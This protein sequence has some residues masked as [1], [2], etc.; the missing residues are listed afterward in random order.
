MST[1]RAFTPRFQPRETL[2]CLHCSGSSGRQWTPMIAALS[3]RFDVKAPDLL[4]YAGQ[5]CW[6]V[7]APASLDDE[8]VALEPLLEGGV[9]LF[10]HSYGGAVALQMALRWPERVKSLTLYEPVRFALLFGNPETASAGQSIVDVGRRI[11]LEVVSRLMP[12]AAAR[13]VDYWSGEG[14]W[15]QLPPQRQQIVI[16]RMP[17]V[18][19]EFEAL[20]ADRVPAS[21]YERLSMP[22]HLIGGSR[23]PLPARQ[24]LDILA[25]HIPHATRVALQG[26]GHMG[27]VEAPQR[28]L[29]AAELLGDA[30][31]RQAA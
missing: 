14:T 28:V 30:E 31:I 7:G 2:L 1:A 8:A 13:F 23:S 21:A 19:A 29:E 22:V 17:K 16:E 26:L 27:P 11:G 4:G 25:A 3:A 9:H 24:V 18:S 12:A 6:A 15:Q 20:F 10:G 5:V